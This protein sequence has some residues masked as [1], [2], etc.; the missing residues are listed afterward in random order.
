M[1]CLGC[2]VYKWS[3]SRKVSCSASL[4]L[5]AIELLLQ[6][7]Q[8]LMIHIEHVWSTRTKQKHPYFPLERLSKIHVPGFTESSFHFHQLPNHGNKIYIKHNSIYHIKLSKMSITTLRKHTTKGF[9]Y[10][11][12]D[13]N[14]TVW[15]KTRSTNSTKMWNTE[16]SPSYLTVFSNRSQ[17]T[18]NY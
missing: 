13:G 3:G 1:L 9:T 12:S 8:N 10:Q 14:P 2:V 7:C 15:W 16:I 6:G 17:I 4:V 18:Q 11:N 5:F